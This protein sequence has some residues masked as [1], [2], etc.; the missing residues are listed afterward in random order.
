MSLASSLIVVNHVLDDSDP[1]LSHQGQVVRLLS[2]HFSHIK[3]ITGR[4]GSFSIPENVSVIDTKWI[5]D[6]KFRSLGRFIWAAVP[7]ILF[8]RHH[9]IFSHMADLQAA[10]ISP[11][12]RLA[13]KR[14]FLW[15]AHSYKSFYLTFASCFVNGIVTSTPG[16]CPISGRKVT[17]IGQSVDPKQFSPRS[18]TKAKNFRF[19]HVGRLD[20]SKNIELLIK[21]VLEVKQ[22]FPQASLT[23]VGSSANS[24]SVDYFQ[25]LRTRFLTEVSMGVINFVPR[26]QRSDLCDAL[27]EHDYFIHAYKGS[28]DKTLIEAT[29][30]RMPV[31][32]LNSEYSK[33][34]GSWSKLE[35]PTLAQE[36]FAMHAVTDEEIA[37]ELRR[38][39]K[40]AE[41]FHSAE[42]W[43]EKLSAILT[44]K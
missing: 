34:F 14:H 1:Y 23:L 32:T 10:L 13:G 39:G 8:G 18:E 42:H 44:S 27:W 7:E 29:L 37:K 43:I 2:Q 31:I 41:D 30:T 3:V 35:D 11:A 36:F 16:S 15:Y 33:I 20:R 25:E 5:P 24:E 17:C 40:I 21:A 6:R 22:R 19:I 9:T 28:L 26:M 38:R 12:A 4:V